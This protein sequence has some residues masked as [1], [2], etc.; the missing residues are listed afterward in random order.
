MEQGQKLVSI[1]MPT[2]Y[3][4]Y[5]GDYIKEAIES[6][7][8]QTYHNIELIISDNASPHR[9]EVCEEYV[10]K[11]K[12]V[13]YIRQKENIG[14]MRNYNFVL[15]GSKGEYFMW[16]CD[17]DLW[18]REY[19]ARCVDVL[20]KKPN[21][22]VAFGKY[23]LF[24]NRLGIR[25][26]FNPAKDFPGGEGGNIY[27]R[28]RSYIL[29]RWTDSKGVLAFGLWRR[30]VLTNNR[31]GDYWGSD[32]NFTFRG[33]MEGT[34]VYI[35]KFLFFKRMNFENEK[36][37]PRGL[38]YRIFRA[39]VLRLG[40]LVSPLFFTFAIDIVKNKKLNLDE[41]IKLLF[42]NLFVAARMFWD[43]KI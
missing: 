8:N 32:M 33:L 15:D 19:I 12:R 3:R 10:R 7:L 34:L 13:H 27:K 4:D 30:S 37:K 6:L 22:V 38:F 41:K 11:D 9:I 1:G 36:M 25:K 17:D 39:L 43:K 42:Y 14:E 31:K 35:D 26:E 29:T 40:W 28:L 2:F 18:D 5:K 24:D 21:A 23:V 16:A 20:K